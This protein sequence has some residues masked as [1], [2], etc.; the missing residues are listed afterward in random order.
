MSDMDSDSGIDSE[1]DPFF[2][3]RVH[4][5][6]AGSEAVN[7]IYTMTAKFDS[8]GKYTRIAPWQDQTREFSVFRCTLRSMQKRWYISIQDQKQ[9]GT[10]NDIDFYRAPP[11]EDNPDYPP[12][13]GWAHC[14]IVN[15][16]V[17]P[18]P[19]LELETVVAKP[20]V[21]TYKKMLFSE[22]FNDVTFI[23]PN[24][25]AV[26]AHKI[27]LAASSSYFDAAFSGSWK[28][29]QSGQLKT[30]H[31]VH[32]IKAMLTSL[33]TGEFD[34]KLIQK[35]PLEFMS[36][37]SE[38]SLETLKTFAESCCIRALGASNLKEIWQAGRLYESDAVKK[39]CIEY[40]KNNTM[41]VLANGAVQHLQTE[42]PASWQEFS[43]AIAP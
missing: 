37:A 19:T 30:T 41:A 12:S 25:E 10:D 18:A 11:S 42:D 33:Y 39:G 6:G 21:A 14:G 43:K 23:C 4:V 20:V 29:S 35:E 28:E 1:I 13:S 15:N 27:V 31:E 24:G 2:G 16:G 5:R 34:T 32:I 22:Q 26:P 9:P 36:V 8:V 3:S 7:G 38:Y 17:R 40:V